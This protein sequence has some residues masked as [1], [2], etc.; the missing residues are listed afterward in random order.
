MA[1]Y[2]G[3]TTGTI[4]RVD[5]LN[6]DGHINE[7]KTKTK[8]HVSVLFLLHFKMASLIVTPQR[9]CTILLAVP[10][11]NPLFK[12]NDTSYKLLSEISL[13]FEHYVKV[14]IF[15]TLYPSTR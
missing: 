7:N 10:L 14:H 3:K 4:D 5:L 12:I 6:R 2:H 8:S 1:A 11:F 15:P 9:K 13:H